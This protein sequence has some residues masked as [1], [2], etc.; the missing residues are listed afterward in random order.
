MKRLLYF[1]ILLFFPI[2]LHSQPKQE[3]RS[4]WITTVFNLDWP[5]ASSNQAT[6][7]SSMINLLDLLKDANF[8]T[9]MLQVRGRGDLLYPSQ[10]EPW[11]R[12]LTGSLGGN[13][14][15][16]PLAFVIEEAH[17]RGMEVHAW[18]NVY[19][20]YS[21][22]NNPTSPPLTNPQHVVNAYPELIKTYSYIS[23]NQVVYDFWMDPGIPGTKDYLLNLGMEMVRNY[24]IDAI[25]FDFIRYPNPDFDDNATYQTYGGGIN[26]SDWRRNNITQF[27]S[28]IY[29]SIKAIKPMMKVGSAPI[30]IYKN[31][32]PCNSGWES[33]TSIFQDSR[34]WL[35]LNKHDYLSPQIY[36]DINSCPRF[37]SLAQNW[38]S[39]SNGKHIYTGIASYR[40]GASDGNWP[41]TEILA[42]VDSS[43]IFG[44][45]GQTFFRTRSFMDNQKSIHNLIKNNH[46][47][48]PAN[49][50]PMPWK[51]GIKPNPPGNISLDTT[52]SL[53]YTVSWSK[54]EPASDG[55]TAIYYNVYMDDKSPVDIE[56]I[57]KMIRF[58]ITEDT[59]VSITLSSVP[60]SNTFFAVTAYDKGYNESA[61]AEIGIVFTSV[62]DEIVINGYELFQNYPNPFN[63]VTAINF[64]LAEAGTTSLIIFDVLGNEVIRLADEYMNEGKHTVNFNADN[65][66]SGVYFYS[67]KSGD[68]MN[69]KKM[70]L[71][72]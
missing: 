26:K 60:S 70:I 52:D 65:L 69:I 29:D 6:Q 19:K 35:F 63:P 64:S 22:T 44:A 71:I 20:V 41:V 33:F 15:Y 30:G 54:P 7:K 11:A 2:I 47:K 18:W 23:N 10:H 12:A 28:A 32:S 62:E 8:N 57:T 46:Y 58:R 56:D 61:P 51:D 14:G 45:D 21:S 43:R 16:D 42:Q 34:R 49:I 37:D 9:I 3:V 50:S 72:R 25:H 67:L 38:V 39:N 48:Y 68:F 1:M 13:P 53:T 31:L 55:D 5:P 40:M 27:V 59:S 36:W 66:S 17:K 4:V 24:N